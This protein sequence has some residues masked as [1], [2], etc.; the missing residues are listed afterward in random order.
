MGIIDHLLQ[1]ISIVGAHCHFGQSQRA[2]HVELG[3]ARWLWRRKG[4]DRRTRIGQSAGRD[5]DEAVDRGPHVYCDR[6]A[7]RSS[8]RGRVGDQDRC[9]AKSADH[10][11]K[12][13]V[14]CP[15]YEPSCGRLIRARDR[16][17]L[18]EPL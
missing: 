16:G 5:L 13:G 11:Q 8:L 18:L 12:N 2:P 15:K 3:G 14:V 9:V 10:P 1:Q 6:I 4:F 7:F 17:L